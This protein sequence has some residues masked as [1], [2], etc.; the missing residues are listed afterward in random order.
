MF[1]ELLNN[2]KPKKEKK[3][4]KSPVQSDH[5]YS[6]DAQPDICLHP[7][8]SFPTSSPQSGIPQC[9]TGEFLDQQN[10]NEPQIMTKTGNL[11][12]SPYLLNESPNYAQIICSEKNAVQGNFKN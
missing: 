4:P 3:E 7:A 2:M 11:N 1:E 9:S 12:N 6:S 5:G 8:P 10:F